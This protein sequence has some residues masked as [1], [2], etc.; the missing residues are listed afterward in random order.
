MI[1]EIISPALL[2]VVLLSGNRK[3]RHAGELSLYF[4]DINFG[5]NYL[6]SYSTNNGPNFSDL[7]SI[8]G[9]GDLTRPPASK[10]A[11][12]GPGWLKPDQKM[13]LLCWK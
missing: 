4:K 12:M 8:F 3:A 13:V 6:P 11:L 1:S 2:P 10:T 9:F 5:D 7:E